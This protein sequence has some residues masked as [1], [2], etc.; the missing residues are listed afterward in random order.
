[1]V[2]C[3]SSGRL[4]GQ[5]EVCGHVLAAGQRKPGSER[6]EVSGREPSLALLMET[7]LFYYSERA[8]N[9]LGECGWVYVT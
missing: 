1:M 5:A 7:L 2:C 8:T 9:G 6:T 3:P 4:A